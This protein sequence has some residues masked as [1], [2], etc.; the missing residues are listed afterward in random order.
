MLSYISIQK[1]CIIF[2]Y[3]M[4]LILN[5]IWHNIIHCTHSSAGY[6]NKQKFH[7]PENKLQVSNLSIWPDS[8]VHCKKK[9]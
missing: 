6:H 4:T 1:Y 7:N 9:D 8:K 3:G 5:F 2:A